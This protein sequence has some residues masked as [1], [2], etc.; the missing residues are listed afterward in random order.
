MVRYFKENALPG[1][2]FDSLEDLQKWIDLWLVKYSDVRKLSLVHTTG[3]Q[4]ETPAERFTQK[5]R[6]ELRTVDRVFFTNIREET[7]KADKCGLIRVE[8]RLYKLPEQYFNQSVFIQ[9][10][11]TEIIFHDADNKDNMKRPP[12][13]NAKRGFTV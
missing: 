3:I 13:M 2:N 9:I 6:S 4:A 10:T 5:E 7:R 12:R 11:D 1:R 8:N